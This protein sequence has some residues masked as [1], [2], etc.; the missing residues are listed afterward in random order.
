MMFNKKLL[1]PKSFF[2]QIYTLMTSTKNKKRT[3]VEKT[4]SEVKNNPA[5]I[6][7]LHLRTTSIQ[8]FFR[9]TLLKFAKIEGG[10][11]LLNIDNNYPTFSKVLMIV[12]KAFLGLAYHF[13]TTFKWHFQ[14]DRKVILNPFGVFIVPN[15]CADHNLV[16]D[17]DGQLSLNLV[18]QE[19]FVFHVGYIAIS[20]IFFFTIGLLEHFK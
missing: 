18:S 6:M 16:S 2:L 12:T 3:I 15:F 5:T 11:T 1:K 20:V 9:V 8:Q 14:R 19:S 10:I 17:P 13:R 7:K 4:S